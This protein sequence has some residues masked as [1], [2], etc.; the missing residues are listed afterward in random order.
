MISTVTDLKQLYE[1]DEL[2]WLR[3]TIELLREKRFHDLDIEH[4]MEELD[5]MGNEKKRGVES[6]LE[7]V[8]RH[9]L[10]LQYWTTQKEMNGTHWR[11]EVYT[12]RVQLKRK[13]T[14]N[15]RNHLASELDNLYQDGLGFVR[16]KTDYQIE[17][18]SQCPY[19]LDQLLDV[20][21]WP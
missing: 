17:F 16:I 11:G 19:S 2:E 12:F 8:I 10:L 6:L 13:L 21:W 18:P 4:L 9:L 15:L 20:N 3:E 1:I 14:T 5:D 7:Q